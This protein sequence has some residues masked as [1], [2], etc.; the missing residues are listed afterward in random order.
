MSSPFAA[1]VWAPH[2]LGLAA[3]L[4]VT[5]VP[6]TST[7]G[8]FRVFRVGNAIYSFAFLD[9]RLEYLKRG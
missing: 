9:K 6:L 2:C 5:H 7:Q 8:V 4:Q 3:V 1:V